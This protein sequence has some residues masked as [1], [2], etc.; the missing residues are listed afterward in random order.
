M[1][2]GQLK[3]ILCNFEFTYL[4]IRYMACGFYLGDT[5]SPKAV[6][7]RDYTPTIVCQTLRVTEENLANFLKCKYWDIN[8]ERLAKAGILFTKLEIYFYPPRER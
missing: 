7:G 6:I 2:V 1:S 3:K 8:Q 5:A 4:G